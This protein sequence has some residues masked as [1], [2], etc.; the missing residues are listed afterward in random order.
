MTDWTTR[1]HDIDIH[2]YVKMQKDRE[3]ELHH[4]DN[5]VDMWEKFGSTMHFGPNMFFWRVFFTLNSESMV[6]F[7][8]YW[9]HYRIFWL[10]DA[11]RTGFATFLCARETRI[12]VKL[13]APNLTFKINNAIC[14]RGILYQLDLENEGWQG[15]SGFLSVEMW[16]NMAKCLLWILLMCGYADSY[17][18]GYLHT[19]LD[20]AKV[21]GFGVDPTRI[22]Y[23]FWNL[24]RFDAETNQ[25]P[26]SAQK[27]SPS[28]ESVHM[29]IFVYRRL[30]LPRTYFTYYTM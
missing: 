23:L 26:S 21:T 30:R 25:S 2:L 19:G 20:P 13:K 24:R 16:Q 29:S 17:I 15:S 18:Y 28:G 22:E 12:N 11:L 5:F 8:G 27:K 1:T 14:V 7:W 6:C 4:L 3:R 9:P 10:G